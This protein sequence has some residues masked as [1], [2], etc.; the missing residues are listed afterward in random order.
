MKFHNL[1]NE[2]L[3][4]QINEKSVLLEEKNNTTTNTLQNIGVSN[5]PDNVFVISLDKKVEYRKKYKQQFNNLLNNKKPNGK[6]INK[7]C[8]GVF[9]SYEDTANCVDLIFCEL[10]SEDP[11]ANTYEYQLINSK[12]FV[13]YVINLYNCFYNSNITVNKFSFVLFYLEKNRPINHNKGL[14]TK[15]PVPV[16]TSKKMINFPNIE[17]IEYPCYQSK[18]QW[19]NWKELMK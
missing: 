6:Y 7:S 12:L 19:I 13:D 2:F 18:F 8:D 4:E 1:I 3:C 17:F 16:P 11:K 5:L 14:R 10:K 15:I 9:I